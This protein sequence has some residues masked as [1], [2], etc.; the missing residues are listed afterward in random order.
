MKFELFAKVSLRQDF[1]K[2]HLHSTIYTKETSQ[3]S[4]IITR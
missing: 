3:P 4:L 2:H 1:S